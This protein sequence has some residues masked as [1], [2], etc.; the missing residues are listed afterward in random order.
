MWSNVVLILLILG[1]VLMR[2]ALK[3][4]T[5]EIGEF[6]WHFYMAG[7]MIGL[8]YAVT[9]NSHMGMDL[10]REKLTKKTRILLD[11]SGTLL[12]LLPFACVIFYQSLEFVHDSWVINERSNND[13]GLPYR[14]LI[15]SVIPLSFGLLIIAAFS[16]LM[17]NFKALSKEGTNGAE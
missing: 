6:Q 9:T 3:M 15:K 16:R 10:V 17:R 5:I 13:M 11:I 14:W 12:L 1:A 8:S 7:F 2:Y 4:R